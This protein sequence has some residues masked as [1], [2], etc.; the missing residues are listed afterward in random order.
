V[1]AQAT[2]AKWTPE[3]RQAKVRHLIDRIPHIPP[4][5]RQRRRERGLEL[6]ATSLQRPDVVAKRDAGRMKAGRSR[7]LTMLAGIPEHRW[8][9]YR[10]LLNKG[11]MTAAEAR[12]II[13]DDTAGTAE[14][15]RRVVAN[16]A[17]AMR[18]RHER[19]LA[20]EY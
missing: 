4:E 13:L 11:G 5:E 17:D 19:R 9:E 1:K 2:I 16:A 18:I 8:P 3:Q 10:Q 6:V 14:H 15:A 7:S 12:R 20:Q